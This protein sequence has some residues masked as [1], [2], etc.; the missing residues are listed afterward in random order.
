MI[1]E[2]I[3]FRPTKQF[4]QFEESA[5]PLSLCDDYTHSFAGITMD[6]LIEHYSQLKTLKGEI[7]NGSFFR[8]FYANIIPA[9]EIETLGYLFAFDWEFPSW[10]QV[11]E[12]IKELP[13]GKLFPGNGTVL[14]NISPRVSNDTEQLW[15]EALKEGLKPELC[16]LKTAGKLH[17]SSKVQDD[18]TDY[19]LLVKKKW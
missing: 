9:K 1:A 7:R 13:K 11:L 10:V 8:N 6:P 19:I 18:E 4:K 15:R 3:I 14:T 17:L 12:I 2:P 16:I 5:C